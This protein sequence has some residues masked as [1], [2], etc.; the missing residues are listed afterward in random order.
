MNM[1]VKMSKVFLG[2]FLKRPHGIFIS[3]NSKRYSNANINDVD[4]ILQ[5]FMKEFLDHK[6]FLVDIF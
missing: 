6:L 2:R 1:K 3:V 4:F 5:I